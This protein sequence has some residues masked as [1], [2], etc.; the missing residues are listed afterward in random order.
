MNRP[1]TKNYPFKYD[2][3]QLRAFL[4][5]AKE[6]SFSKAAENLFIS[7]PAISRKISQLESALNCQLFIRENNTVRLTP[8]GDELRDQLPKIFDNLLEATESLNSL[9]RKKELRLGYT[10]AAMS[11]FFP[12][13]IRKTAAQ[14]SNYELVFS[15]NHNTALINEVV[16]NTIHGAF[17][18]SQPK[19]EDLKTIHIRPE[20]LGIMIPE[21]HRFNALNE[22]PL[23]LL[24][25]E[26]IIL[27]PRSQ[28]PDLYDHILECCQAASFLPSTIQEADSCN[29]IF[30]FVAAECGVAFVAESMAG[31]CMDGTKYKPLIQ[32]GP[33]I[34]FSFIINKSLQEEWPEVFESTII[35]DYC[36][37]QMV[38]QRIS[39]NENI[40]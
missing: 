11:S 32:P 23:E 31:F 15:E 40:R 28:N 3:K 1:I 6:K 14:L 26:T 37:S 13:M 29:A 18:M 8:A 4:E 39:R 7:Q 22:I 16:T 5:I 34:N 24:K 27:F 38:S 9:T 2:L 33:K 10:C 21:N 20:S 30:G 12:G 17:V 36:E 19:L 35:S 25:D